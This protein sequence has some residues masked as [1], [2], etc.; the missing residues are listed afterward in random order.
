MG[1]AK[2]E[3][4]ACFQ[5]P[6]GI[7][8]VVMT[9]HFHGTCSA[10]HDLQQQQARSV[11]VQCGLS[12]LRSFE[13]VK[14][15]EQALTTLIYRAGHIHR[16]KHQRSQKAYAM[17]WKENRDIPQEIMEMGADSIEAGSLRFF[18]NKDKEAYEQ[19]SPKTKGLAIWAGADFITPEVKE[20]LPSC[21]HRVCFTSHP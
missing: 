9:C 18:A 4:S 1:S 6:T 11:N 17:I 12:E 7:I 15:L 21:T 20:Q 8:T 5:L 19:L 2:I 10:N 3:S 14:K 16:A 13:E